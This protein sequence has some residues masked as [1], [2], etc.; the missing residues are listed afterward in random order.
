MKKVLTAMFRRSR[1][2]SNGTR[3]M[4]GHRPDNRIAGTLYE[5]LGF[6]QVSRELI[7]GEI[8]RLLQIGR[9]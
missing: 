3:I 4:I 2:N 6:I 9:A 7:D 8:V 1:R 5:S